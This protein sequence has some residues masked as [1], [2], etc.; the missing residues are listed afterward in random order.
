MNVEDIVILYRYNQWANNKVLRAANKV[1]QEQMLE[2]TSWLSGETLLKTLIHTMDA[3]WSWRFVCQQGGMP[4]VYL[5][6]ADLPSFRKAWREEMAQ[7]LAYVTSLND[8][9]LHQ[10]IT[11]T[12]PRFQPRHRTLWHILLHI[13]NH[14]T[15]HRAEVGQYLASCGHSPGDMDFM[16]FIAK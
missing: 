6:F 9:Q 14:S 13:V 2:P 8:N 1:S 7:M 16:I 11:Y 10:I 3:E 5:D 4:G 15:H 12:R